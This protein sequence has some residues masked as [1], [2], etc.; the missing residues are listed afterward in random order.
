MK[1][2]NLFRN[3]F[4]SLLSQVVLLIVGFLSQRA[5]NLYMGSE[6][7]GMN[8][9]ISNVIAMLS[10]TE[11]G[12]STAIVY[13]LYSALAKN[14]EEE[15]ASLMNLYRKAYYLFAIII[16]VLGLPL[17]PIVHLFMK[18]ESY[19]LSYIRVLYLLWL[20]RS[21]IS[22]PLSYKKSV[23][24]ADQREYVVSVITMLTNIFS[25]SA[26]IIFVTLTKRYLPA[27]VVGIVVETVLNLWVS[28]YVDRKYPFLKRL[29]KKKPSE[30]VVSKIFKDLKN[31]FVSKVSQNLL[32]CTDNLIISSF[33]SVATVGLFN[34][35]C[36]I[37]R[38]INNI[39]GALANSIQPSVGNL[40]VEGDH[41]KDYR[42]LR[43]LTFLF[44]L[45]VAVASCGLYT[46]INPF[47]TDIWLDETF[48]LDRI[49]V[50]MAVLAC[51]F[52]GF[53]LPMAIVMGVS[54]LFHKERNLSII[55][56]IVNLV[57]SVALVI[58]FGVSGVLAGTCLSYLI[59]IV[60]RV[61]VFFR[62]YLQKDARRYLMDL[63]EYIFLIAGETCLVRFVSEIV[64]RRNIG[65][66]LLCGVLCVGIPLAVNVLL[67][68]KSARLKS[69][70][71]LLHRS[72]A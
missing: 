71:Q 4:F 59:Q 56:A 28:W 70:A 54:G 35:Y 66:F 50:I 26:I 48:Q 57:V 45:I 3:S 11:L 46:L 49:A 44:F 27:L 60:Y 62:E 43:Q 18:N 6:L 47:V 36:L 12:V 21:V 69:I 17:T 64:Y 63:A 34:N 29:R 37:T 23:L 51:I 24:I 67:Y 55:I 39:M 72:A 52:Q 58:P 53:G 25:Y 65:T 42:M 15:I 31:V 61:I 16:T 22:Y 38:S 32:N 13:H 5:M 14:D 68:Q 1:I 10:V 8:G 7:V 2:K 20:M 33:I 30:A 9:V 19:S 41:E 40:F